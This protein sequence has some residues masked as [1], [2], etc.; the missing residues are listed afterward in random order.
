[1]NLFELLWILY[2]QASVV[3]YI[4]NL[5]FW[6][7]QTFAKM[8]LVPV[9]EYQWQLI[10]HYHQ[11][12]GPDK[13]LANYLTEIG[14]RILDLRRHTKLPQTTREHASVS[15]LSIPFNLCASSTHIPITP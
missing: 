9:I 13:H 15:T 3:L 1:M 5:R 4:V 11:Q 14:N 2:R 8:H 12:L 10:C 6:K 7:S